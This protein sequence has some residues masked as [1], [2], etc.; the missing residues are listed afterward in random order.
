M[1]MSKDEKL[2]F[3]SLHLATLKIRYRLGSSHIFTTYKR[4]HESAIDF[5]I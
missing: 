1:N 5:Y 4:K 3:Q 2:H